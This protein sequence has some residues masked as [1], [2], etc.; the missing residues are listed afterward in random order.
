MVSTATIKTACLRSGPSL[1]VFT[2][3]YSVSDLGIYVV[4]GRYFNIL[5]VAPVGIDPTPLG[6]IITTIASNP[7]ISLLV[8]S[9]TLLL[10]APRQY[11][12]FPSQLEKILIVDYLLS[13]YHPVQPNNYLTK[14][15]FYYKI[16]FLYKF[17]L[18]LF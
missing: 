6:F 12:Y 13:H 10:L 15:Y 7:K 11:F 16:L 4:S 17:L 14:N 9:V 1:A 18:F 3:N 5:L 8:Q 2:V